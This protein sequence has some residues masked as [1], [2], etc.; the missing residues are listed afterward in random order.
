[1][2]TPFCT[3]PSPVHILGESDANS[4]NAA[5]YMKQLESWNPYMRQLE[6]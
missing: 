5:F 1:M 6:D 2:C 3:A 4:I